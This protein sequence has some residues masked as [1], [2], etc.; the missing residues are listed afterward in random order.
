[1]KGIAS[2]F[3]FLFILSLFPIICFADDIHLLNNTN[4]YGTAH[5]SYSP[6]SSAAGDTGIMHPHGTLVVPGSAITAFC[7]PFSCDAHL[8][9]SKDCSG[10]EVATITISSRKGIIAI[11]NHDPEHLSLSGSG[12]QGVI[13]PVSLWKKWFG[14]MF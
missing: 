10:K 11:K 6:C 5:V 1:M 8:Y 13:N 2:S 9:M 12:S 14:F 7:G 3:L 4:F